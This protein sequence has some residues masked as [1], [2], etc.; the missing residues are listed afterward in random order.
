MNVYSKSHIGKV[1]ATNQDYCYVNKIDKNCILAVVCDGMGGVSGGNVA[2]EI[3]VKAVVEEIESKLS[4]L[5]DEPSI[6]RIMK[7]AVNVANMVIY[8]ISEHERDLSGMGTT[9]VVA[10]VVDRS[11]Y[12]YHAGDSRAYLINDDIIQI[13]KDHSFVQTMLDLGQISKDE[14]K[15]HPKKNIITRAL[16]I[17]EVMD[18]EYNKTVLEENEILLICTDGLTNHVSDE[19]I[20]KIVKEN[21]NPTD[22]LIK[23]ANENGG[24]DNITVAVIR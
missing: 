6:K 21:D 16:G 2:S 18:F 4:T 17:S 7:N 1:R 20:L 13:T 10:I 23:T 22:K 19:L 11:C 24:S 15:E 14:A 12:I 5:R 9:I 3:A 8:Q